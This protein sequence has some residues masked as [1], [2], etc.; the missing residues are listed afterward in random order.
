MTRE[1]FLQRAQSETFDIVVVGG[2]ATGLGA[3]VDASSRGYT[4]CLIEQ[5]DFAKGTSS[6]STKLIHG[7]VR[8]LRQG[9]VSMVLGALKERERLLHNA[10]HLVHSVPFA[11]P[12]YHWWET[13]FY[14]TGLKLY[15]LLARSGGGFERS[16]LLGKEEILGRLPSLNTSGLRGGVLYHD[17]QFDDARL[18]ISLAKTAVDHSAV[19]LNYVVCEGFFRESGRIAG[20]V[21]K[22]T[23]QSSASFEIKGKCVINA[24][25]VFS[26][27][28]RRMDNAQSGPMVRPSQGIHVVLPNDFLPGETGMLI[29]KTDDGRVLFAVPWHGRIVAG[30]TD[31]PIVLPSLEPRALPEESDYLLAH[32]GRYFT[33]QPGPDDVLSTFAG[34]RP[35]VSKS[36]TGNTAA[37][38]RDHVITQSESGLITIAGGK[39]TTYRKMAEDVIDVAAKSGAVAAAPCRTVELR[40]N[41]A[42]EPPP[43]VRLPSRSEVIHFV[44]HEMARTIEDVL[45]RRTRALIL[46]ARGAHDAA[47]EIGAIMAAELD[48]STN[49]TNEQVEKFQQIAVG[50]LPQ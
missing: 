43:G 35:L 11:I 13:P 6:R 3:A 44:Q 49:V 29:P 24:T 8:Y 19:M 2:G 47:P 14:G 50:Y 31:T 18:A 37:L 38:S 1:S 16:S 17:G 23:E 34:L 33:R 40:L 9:R 20:V 32:L 25:G 39:W 22:D 10:P 4:V 5:S 12:S 15:D 7:G 41:G 26:D 28:L 36:G 21:A 42:N 45:S 27:A 48:W 30:T 46:D